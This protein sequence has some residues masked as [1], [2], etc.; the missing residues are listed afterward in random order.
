MPTRPGELMPD[1]PSSPN[2]V[3][4]GGSRPVSKLEWMQEELGVA[5]HGGAMVYHGF[6]D[7]CGVGGKH[8]AVFAPAAA[9]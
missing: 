5:R 7:E 4:G 3:Q 2:E 8:C 9:N 1:I 6:V